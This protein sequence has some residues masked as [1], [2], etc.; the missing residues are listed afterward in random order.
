MSHKLLT[1]PRLFQFILKIDAD[2][3]AAASSQACPH[4]NSPLDRADYWRKPRGLPP[5]LEDSFR[6]R[7]SFC[8]CAEGCRRRQTPALMAFLGRRVYVSAVI[9][10]VAAMQQGATPVRARE[11]H[12]LLGVS[13]RTI[14][15]WLSWWKLVFPLTAAWRRASGA[16]VPSID[17]TSLPASLLERLVRLRG[18]IF[19]GVPSLLKLVMD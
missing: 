16:L 10:L 8:C 4:C 1:D 9:V 13:R 5:A 12:L 18:D 14:G 6:R 17:E 19:G 3:V 7:P 2:T 15:R 11:L